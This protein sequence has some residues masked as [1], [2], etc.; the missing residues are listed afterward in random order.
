MKVAGQNQLI[1]VSAGMNFSN[2]NS[3][4]FVTHFRT[5]FTAGL[6]Y[7]Y[8]YK[9]NFSLGADLIYNQRGFINKII[10][11]DESGFSTGE[12]YP[13]DFIYNYISVPL[14]VGFNSGDKVYVFSNIGIIP[15]FLLEAKTVLPRIDNDL[16]VTGYETFDLSSNASNFDLGGLLEIGGGY[17]FKNGLWLYTSLT[18]QHSFTT[19]S[20]REYLTNS[21]LRHNG[22]LLS[23]GLKYALKN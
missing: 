17:K 2:V 18:Y 20:N 6:N 19:I 4:D 12:E 10:L 9:S 13:T 7:E 22:A 21:T 14:K 5:G 23:F 16:N 8:L 1:G 15:S 11:T 3:K